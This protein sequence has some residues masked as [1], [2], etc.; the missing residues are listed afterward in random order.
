MQA[1]LEEKQNPDQDLVYSEDFTEMS[2]EFYCQLKLNTDSDEEEDEEFSFMSE[3][4]NTSPIAAE[5]AFVNGQIK[6]I[7]PLFNQESKILYENLP[8]RPATKRVFVE[9]EDGVTSSSLGNDDINVVEASPD[10]CTKSNSTGFSKV[11]R[12]KDS[13]G[14]SNSDG[15]DAFVFLN[16]NNTAP[17]RTAVA[18]AAGVREKKESSVKVNGKVKNSKKSQTASFVSS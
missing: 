9:T 8:M 15:R 17:S 18:A 11:W 4:A 14:R 12:F 1:N 5:D 7:F 6:T 13:M 10:V 16:S 3:G 2:Q